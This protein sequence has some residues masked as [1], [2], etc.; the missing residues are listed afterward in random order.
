MNETA[1]KRQYET[2]K[3]RKKG[4]PGLF[5]M[6]FIVGVI[7]LIGGIGAVFLTN[8][9]VDKV[10]ASSGVIIQIYVYGND[11]IIDIVGGDRVSELEYLFVNIADYELSSS[12]MGKPVEAGQTKVIYEGFFNKITGERLVAVRGLF[13][14]GKT[15]QILSR[16]IRFS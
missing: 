11:M 12:E 15:V 10:E 9:A 1:K 13:E 4:T 16:E 3:P 6:V 2:I 5:V 7:L 14:N 8:A